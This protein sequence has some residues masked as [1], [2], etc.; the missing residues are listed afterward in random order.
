MLIMQ[1]TAARVQMGRLYQSEREKDSIIVGTSAWYDWLECNT[2]FFF[3]D[4]AGA[5]TAR[6]DGTDLAS[7]D[8]QAYR[9]R[10]RKTY[11]V[12][13]GR[14]NML[15]LERLQAV[16]QTLAGEHAQTEPTGTSPAEPIASMPQQPRTRV[17]IS[18]SRSLIQTKLYRPRSSSDMIHRA[19]LIERLNAGLGGNV[20]LVSAPAGFGKTTLLAEWMQTLDRPSAWLSLDKHDNE[21]AVFVHSL[22]AA[23]QTVLP[24]AFQ[25]MASLLKAP[26]F[27]PADYVAT[28]LINELADMS[29]NIILVLDD[30][31]LICNSEVHAL[32]DRLIEHLPLQLHLVIATRSD[33]PLPFA[34]WSVQG[35]L[36]ELRSAHLRFTLEETEIFLARM[37]GNE[38]VH[39]TA[40]A[41]EELTEGWIVVLRLAALSLLSTSDRVAFMVR[42]RSSPD[43][44]MSSYLIEEVLAQQAPAVQ[45]LLVQTSMLEQFCA[46]LC[47]SRSLGMKTLRNK[48][49]TP[50]T[51]WYT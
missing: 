41:L 4:Y 14:S 23:L 20:T 39:E 31:H 30:Y 49:K 1:L 21:L 11:R 5:F 13:L 33:P 24:D 34:R 37:L 35:H 3:F 26:Q 47:V 12:R 19:R 46:E 45:E 29:E 22:V 15:T 27:P 51:G 16:A 7:S 17:N 18:F 10:H 25:A 50:W 2:V 43:R 9:I 40:V 32:L 48:C 28:L 44:N 36:N 6:K 8:W 42:L 38:L